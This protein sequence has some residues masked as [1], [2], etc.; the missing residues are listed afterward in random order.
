MLNTIKCTV[1]TLLRT[2]GVMVWSLAFPLIMLGIFSMMFSSLDDMADMDPA[3]LAAVRPAADAD[4][5]ASG[6][7]DGM[8]AAKA[9]AFESLMDAVSTG[10]DRLF[11]L[12]WAASAQEAEELVRASLADERPLL[13]YVELVDGVPVA[14]VRDSLSVHTMES[15]E[16]LI[17]TTVLDEYA[18]RTELA[19]QLLA[20]DPAALADPQVAASLYGSVQATEQVEVTH[21]Q[22][23]ESV[24]YYFA[25]M[26]MA[27]LFGGSVGLVAVQRMR[28]NASALGA[29]RAVSGLSHGRA[30]AA[31]LFACWLVNF[32]CLTVAVLVMRFVVGVDFGN[33][34]GACLAVTAAASLTALSLG[35]AVSAIP[36]LPESTKSGILTGVVCFASLFAGLYG[37]PTMELADMVA[38]SAPWAAWV[39]P[40]AQIAQAFYSVMYYDSFGPL[41][42]HVGT[43]LVMAAVLFLLA[44]GSLRRQRYASI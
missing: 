34:E 25:L 35:C 27:A 14:H 11:T 19:A 24:R 3:P 17:L 6:N 1:L 13:G 31:T 5:N 20:D 42:V 30:M 9:E 16:A 4:A 37:Q 2:P 21:N 8:A 28:P 41:L 33:R 7:A 26:G 10:D 36:K 32:A 44:V 43:L 40:A 22:P 12:M 23:K 38:A 18:A 29:R 15:A 39:N